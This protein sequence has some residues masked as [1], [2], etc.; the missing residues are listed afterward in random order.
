MS[1]FPFLLRLLLLVVDVDTIDDITTYHLK[2]HANLNADNENNDKLNNHTSLTN[3]LNL[4]TRYHSHVSE[5][6]IK[7]NMACH[8]ALWYNQMSETL[9]R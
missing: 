5:T 7:H 3:L 4:M 9:G 1:A 8:R 2:L 6:D